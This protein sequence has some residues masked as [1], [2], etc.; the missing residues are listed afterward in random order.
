MTYL[1]DVNALLSLAQNEH[2]FHRRM[3]HWVHSL[4]RDGSDQLATC[5]ITELGFVRILPQI[6]EAEYTVAEARGLLVRLKSHALVPFVFYSDDHGADRLPSWVKAAKHTTDGHLAELAK[7]H[8]AIL[9]TLD[10][11]IPGAFVMPEKGS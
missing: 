7:A 10:G 8:G 9:A 11:K 6:P 4:A 3:A 1:L 2:Q 5:A